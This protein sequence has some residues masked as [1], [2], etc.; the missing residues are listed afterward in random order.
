MDGFLASFFSHPMKQRSMPIIQAKLPGDFRILVVMLSWHLGHVMAWEVG[1]I[2]LGR[3]TAI[4][5]TV[6]T[7][8]AGKHRF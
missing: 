8:I 1:P 2:R 6:A 5:G 4:W 3:I 7:E